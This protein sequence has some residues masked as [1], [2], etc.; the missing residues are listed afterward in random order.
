MFVTGPNVVKTVTHEDVDARVPRRRDDPHDEERRRPSRGA[1]TRRPRSTRCAR[2]SP[3]CR[4]TTSSTPPWPHRTIRP[5]RTGWTRARLGRPGRPAQPY[6]MHDVLSRRR[7][8]RRLPRDPAGLGGRTSSSGSRGSAAAASGSSPSSL[9]S[10]PARSTSTRRSRRPGSSGRA[11][12]STSRSSRSSTS[13]ASCPG[14]AP[15]ARRDHPARRE[16]AV[17]L[18]RGDG[19]EADG[20]HPQ[21]LRRR[22]RRHEQ[23]AH[24]GRHELRLADGRDRGDGRGGRR[25]HH[26]QRDAI[27]AA[28]GPGCRACPARRRHTRPRFANPYVA[29]APRLR[30]RRH[31]AVGDA[32]AADPRPRRCSPT[33][34][35]RTRG[36]SMATSRSDAR[37]G[38]GRVFAQRR[39]GAPFRRV[40]IAN[41]GEIAVRIIRACHELGIEAVAV[42]SDADADALH[43][44]LAD[45]AVR[46][47]PAAPAESYLRI[48]A[49]VEAAIADR[50]RGDPSGLRVPGR[51]G[52]LRRA[53][54]RTPGSPSSVRRRRSIEALGDKLHARRLA[55]AVG[56]ATVPGTL[57][58]V[59]VDRPDQVAADR[60]G[61]RGRSASRCWSRRPPAAAAGACGGSTRAVGPA[62]R[63]GRRVRRGGRRPSATGSVYLERE[64]R[65]GA[66]HRG[67]A[68]RRRDGQRRRDRRARLLAPAAPPEA[69]RGGAGARSDAGEPASTS[70]T[71][72]VRVAA[73]AGLPQRG[74]RRVPA[75]RRRG[76]LLPRGQHP[77][78]GRARRHRARL[79]AR[80]RPRAVLA[81][82]RP[83][84]VRR[85]A[86][87]RRDGPPSP[88]VHAI[89]VRLAA[90]DPAATSPRPRA[91][92]PLGDAGGPGGPGRYR[93]SRPGDRVPPDYD[94]LVAKIMVHRRRT[95]AAAIDRLRRAL[96]ETEIG[97]IQT[98][99]P[100]HRFVA[101]DP[102]FRAGDLSTDWVE[103]HWD[104]RGGPRATARA[105]GRSR[106]RHHGRRRPPRV[107][108]PG[109]RDHDVRRDGGPAPAT[110]DRLALVAARG[111]RR[112]TGGPR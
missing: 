93:R 83:A 92:P 8:R 105:T 44:R 88:P 89:E 4:R 14:V 110:S 35:T 108:A 81:G 101:R 56:V 52:G 107:P 24:P 98:T 63:A 6:D 84:A 46:L 80:Y 73:A 21:G 49:I 100:F 90:E 66:P 70:M 95:G 48:D 82:R 33:S 22:V 1:A 7:R 76:V 23:Q 75:D 112:S 50:G 30:R 34:A 85:G 15:G 41:R 26:L 31:P 40:L 3:T 99:L 67:P 42:Y 91:R 29:A 17:C 12:A 20:H 102:A 5:D 28:D 58:P 77:A 18:L 45:R 54:S 37:E 111:R 71:W 78:P 94:N 72:R 57:D 104:G 10:S 69:G 11:T 25:Q 79:R 61:G 38:Q 106:R 64:I 60:R 13:R 51:A 86:R 68:A 27:A 2:C 32:A 96:D 65:P 39:P 59:P 74:D 62:R 53:P 109:S 16:A 55:R 97:G 47:G 9:R 36:R 103:E 87:R 43:V 19:P